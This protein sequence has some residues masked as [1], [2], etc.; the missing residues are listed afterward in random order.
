MV[1]TFRW[2]ANEAWFRFEEVLIFQI[3]KLCFTL[4]KLARPSA[5]RHCKLNYEQKIFWQWENKKCHFV[6]NGNDELVRMCTRMKIAM[7]LHFKRQPFGRVRLLVLNGS[8]VKKKKKKGNVKYRNIVHGTPAHCVYPTRAHSSA[9][10]HEHFFLDDNQSH[11]RNYIMTTKC[12]R[13]CLAS[14]IMSVC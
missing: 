10:M 13:A 8:L 9:C 4:L 11:N 2:R 5:V 12:N 14:R 1:L 3:P 6:G 7:H